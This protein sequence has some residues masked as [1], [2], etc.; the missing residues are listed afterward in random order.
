MHSQTLDGVPAYAVSQACAAYIPNPSTAASNLAS[1]IFESARMKMPFHLKDT[2]VTPLPVVQPTKS[3][4]KAFAAYKTPLFAESLSA[5]DSE[6]LG[7][8]GATTSRSS[9]HDLEFRHLMVRTP[10]NASYPKAR[11]TLGSMTAVWEGV[12]RVSARFF[13]GNFGLTNL[14]SRLLMHLPVQQQ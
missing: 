2:R 12:F 10:S 11:Y 5:N 14:R 1:V 8:S 9:L 7:I 4:F 6:T 3:D 13:S